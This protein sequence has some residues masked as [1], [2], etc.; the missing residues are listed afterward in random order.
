MARRGDMV[1]SAEMSVEELQDLGHSA[2]REPI[3]GTSNVRALKPFALGPPC[4][5]VRPTLCRDGRRPYASEARLDGGPT[6]RQV[7]GVSVPF[8]ELRRRSVALGHHLS[9]SPFRIRLPG[10]NC[11]GELNNFLPV[12]ELESQ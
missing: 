1:S 5:G 10:G 11:S 8:G 9:L 12:G 6:R 3:A 7:Q 2:G 4:S